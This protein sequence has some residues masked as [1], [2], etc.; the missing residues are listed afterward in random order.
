MQQFWKDFSRVMSDHRIGGAMVITG[1]IFFVID[2]ISPGVTIED[3]PIEIFA[4]ALVTLGAMVI[5]LAII[6]RLRRRSRRGA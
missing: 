6:G 5:V 3:A 1:L 2:E 4:W